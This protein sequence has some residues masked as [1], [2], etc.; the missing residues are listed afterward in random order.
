MISTRLADR[1]AGM[2]NDWSCV[3]IWRLRPDPIENGAFVMVK[4]IDDPFCPKDHPDEPLLL[5]EDIA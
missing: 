1:R 2:N 4:I 5:E 3:C